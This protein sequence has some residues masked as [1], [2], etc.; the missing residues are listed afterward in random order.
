MLYY[1]YDGYGGEL[2]M[3]DS[4]TH[5]DRGIRTLSILCDGGGGGIYDGMWHCYQES[6]CQVRDDL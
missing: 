1:D 2:E 6:A 4:T 5:I 3:A